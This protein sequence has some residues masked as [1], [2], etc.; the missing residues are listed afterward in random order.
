MLFDD[1]KVNTI[2]EETIATCFGVSHDA[3]TNA[4]TGYVLNYA[5][6]MR[7][8]LSKIALFQGRRSN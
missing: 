1:E 5:K 2:D 7:F 6:S 8:L 3:L 4:E